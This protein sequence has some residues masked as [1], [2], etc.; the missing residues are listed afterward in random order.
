LHK[1]DL[2]AMLGS[3]IAVVFLVL[4]LVILIRAVR[5]S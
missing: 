2:T 1:S 5:R 4:T 3:P